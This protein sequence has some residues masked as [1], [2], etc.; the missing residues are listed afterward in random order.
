MIELFN[1]K[2]NKQN[3]P[4]IAINSSKEFLDNFI[5]TNKIEVQM[6]KYHLMFSDLL[7]WQIFWSKKSMFKWKVICNGGIII[8]K[9]AMDRL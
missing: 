7:K 4:L 3:Y 1:S 9:N 5:S 8:L 2:E 6:K